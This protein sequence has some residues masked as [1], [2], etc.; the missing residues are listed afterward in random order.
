MMLDADLDRGLHFPTTGERPRQAVAR[1]LVGRHT[2]TVRWP[3]VFAL[4]WV[5][6]MAVARPAAPPPRPTA[7]ERGNFWRDMIDP[8]GDQVRQLVAKAA[9]LMSRPDGAYAS[10]TEWAVDARTRFYREAYNVLVHARRLSPE[11]VQVLSML[12]RA[13]DEIG[14]T[15]KALEALESCVRITGVEKAAP[16]DL[17]QLGN[18]MIRFGDLDGAIGRLRHAQGLHGAQIDVAAPALVQLATAH[19][20]KGD[21]R[22]AIDVLSSAL[23]DYL[24]EYSAGV[25]LAAFAL[26]VLYDRDE[27]G[28]A[29]FEILDHMQVS[30]QQSY[31][32]KVNAEIARTR[33]AVPEDVHYYRALLYESLG[34]YVEARAEWAHYAAAGDPRW[35]GRASDHMAAIDAERRASPIP[36]LPHIPPTLL[37]RRSRP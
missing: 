28:G 21:H 33:F 8:N 36:R 27:Q 23:P 5:P 32:Q 25:T 11:N 4:A 7:S 22:A 16:E 18:L 15:R 31:A 24:V 19:A 26:A 35:R 14:A 3:W 29:A 1:P 20:Q 2:R 6:A 17:A 10:D 12:G 9:E 13:A 37:R 34:H 30:M